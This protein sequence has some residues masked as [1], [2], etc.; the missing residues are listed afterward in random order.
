MNHEEIISQ[1]KAP[2]LFEEVE[3]KVQVTNGEK[4]KGMAVFYLDAR[5]V[6]ERL[7]MVLGTFGWRN[8]YIMWQ[9][10][11]QICGLSL[12]NDE[13]CEWITKYD[14][15]EN[16]DIEAVKGGLTDA[17]KR[18]AVLWGIGR[19]LYQMEGIWVDVEQRGKGS[20]I[21]DN[22]KGKLKSEY[23][24]AIAK[25][26]GAGVNQEK[27]SSASANTNP[28]QQPPVENNTPLGCYR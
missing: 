11:S 6:Q 22:Q 17:F 19:Y 8:E 1:L 21:K 5:A 25:I 26:F 20:F 14:G 13:R 15:A 28:P 10:K 9:D 24:K 12:Y 2:F 23:D 3:A 4:T 7:D 18:S 16:S 27:A